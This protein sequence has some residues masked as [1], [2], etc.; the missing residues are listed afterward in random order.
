M[1]E[2]G[3]AFRGC[4]SQ[5]QSRKAREPLAGHYDPAARSIAARA[6]EDNAGAGSADPEPKI[7]TVER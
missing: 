4:D 3:V 5:P 6:P 7:A 1:T 2:R